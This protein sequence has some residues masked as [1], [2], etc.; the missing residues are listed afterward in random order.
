MCARYV[1]G[2]Y[3]QTWVRKLC[4]RASGSGYLTCSQAGT[5]CCLNLIPCSVTSSVLFDF[6][7]L[8]SSFGIWLQLTKPQG[9]LLAWKICLGTLEMWVLSHIIRD[10]EILSSEERCRGVKTPLLSHQ[11]LQ[12]K[13]DSTTDFCLLAS[14]HSR[15][16]QHYFPLTPITLFF[17]QEQIYISVI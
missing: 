11:N 17:C 9:Y 15:P 8:R 6:Q 14:S 16:L 1:P 12:E 3:V 7:A 10:K 5:I 13:E 2:T 4:F